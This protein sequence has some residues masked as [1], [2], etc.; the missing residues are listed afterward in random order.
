MVAGRGWYD[1]PH[2]HTHNHTHRRGCGGPRSRRGRAHWYQACGAFGRSFASGRPSPKE[3]GRAGRC[4]SSGCHVRRRG[5]CP[6]HTHGAVVSWPEKRVASAFRSVEKAAARATRNGAP[7]HLQ[8]AS[9]VHL[10]TRQSPGNRRCAPLD[11]GLGRVALARRLDRPHSVASRVTA[12][13]PGSRGDCCWPRIGSK[14][15][16]STSVPRSRAL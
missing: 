14:A 2:P 16:R 11:V 1:L 13:R 9:P 10:R 6:F 15:C 3:G 5:T 12:A 4:P 8:P 7:L